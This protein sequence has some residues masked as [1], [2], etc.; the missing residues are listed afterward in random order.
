MS[1]GVLPDLHEIWDYDH[2]DATET[3]F[4]ALLPDVRAK[5][6]PDEIGQLLSQIART[7]GLQDDFAGAHA[8][9]DEAD[10]LLTPACTIGRIRSLLERGRTLN[11]SGK[12]A[13]SRAKFHRAFVRAYQA[14]ADA[15]AIDALHM[16]G[17]VTEPDEAIDWNELAM[18]MA[19]RSSERR[20]QQWLASLYQNQGYT[21][22]ERE[23]LDDAM[24]CFERMLAFCLE[25]DRTDRVRIARWFIGRTQRARGDYDAALATQRDLLAEYEAAGESDA[26]YTSEEI[27]EC[28]LALDR[29]DE[30][31][32]YFAVAH[33]KL[34]AIGWLV[35]EEPE[36]IA[37]LRELGG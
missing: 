36:R 16:L 31:R 7:R 21:Y 28:L 32:P 3:R 23:A 30:A 33:E 35:R 19:E 37:R 6:T 25:H 12:R 1:D 5:G 14:D 11:A 20:A 18:T 10:A 27:G 15:Y 34:S 26:G 17:I 29:R 22:L 4:R 8:L 2:P 13:E 9:L 24:S